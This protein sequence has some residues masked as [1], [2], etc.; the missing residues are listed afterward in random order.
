MNPIIEKFKEFQKHP[1]WDAWGETMGLFFNICEYSWHLGIT[2]Q[3]KY[4]YRPSPVQI[5][6]DYSEEL[7]DNMYLFEDQLR[8]DILHCMEILHRYTRYLTFKG[9]DY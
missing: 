7:K 4:E 2:I 8:V 3:S 6:D 1:N 9:E 5:A